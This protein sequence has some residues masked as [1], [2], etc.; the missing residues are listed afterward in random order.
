MTAM[1]HQPLSGRF[2]GS[3]LSLRH[4]DCQRFIADVR[5]PSEAVGLHQAHSGSTR[6]RS[7]CSKAVGDNRR[8]TVNEPCTYWP[9][10]QSRSVRAC[11]RIPDHLPGHAGQERW[12][13]SC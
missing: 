2:F 10:L 13:A 9:D 6:L 11:A 1:E 8:S 12:C 7:A 5:V 4:R 3:R